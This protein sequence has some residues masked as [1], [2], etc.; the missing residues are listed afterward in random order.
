MAPKK[1]ESISPIQTG[2]AE[3]PI[4]TKVIR[5]LSVSERGRNADSIPIGKAINSQTMVPPITSDPVTGSALAMIS[6]T[7]IGCRSE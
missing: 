3:T 2:W 7:E 4:R 5:P 6:R 1:Y